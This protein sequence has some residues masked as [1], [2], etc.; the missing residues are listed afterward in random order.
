MGYTSQH[1]TI[2]ATFGLAVH[3]IRGTAISDT[4][5]AMYL[6]KKYT[7]CTH[8]HTHT[9]LV[10]IIKKYHVA[11]VNPVMAV[12]RY[13]EGIKINIKYVNC[14]IVF[15]RFIFVVVDDDDPPTGGIYS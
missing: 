5:I 8:I 14:H 11:S 1:I 12:R 10:Q 3:P 13:Y 6:K 9:N 15:I 4:Y 2:N 7:I